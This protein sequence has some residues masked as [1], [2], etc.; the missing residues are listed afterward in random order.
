M[1]TSAL[2][3]NVIRNK[4]VVGYASTRVNCSVLLVI[5]DVSYRWCNV[6]PFSIAD[7]PEE[8]LSAHLLAMREHRAHKHVP[9]LGE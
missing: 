6:S 2:G 7:K 3:L 1:Y 5:T 9:M 4:S 8:E